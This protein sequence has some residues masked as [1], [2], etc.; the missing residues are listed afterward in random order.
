MNRALQTMDSA[1]EECCWMEGNGWRAR[2]SGEE[3]GYKVHRQLV[4]T[5]GSAA[6][7]VTC[8]CSTPQCTP[9]RIST[10]SYLG[11]PRCTMK[12]CTAQLQPYPD[13]YS[14]ISC[15]LMPSLLLRPLSPTCLTAVGVGDRRFRGSWGR[16]ESGRLTCRPGSGQAG[17]QAGGQVNEQLSKQ[18][19]RETEQ[20]HR[21][22]KHMDAPVLH[23]LKARD[24][25][26]V[27]HRLKARDRTPVLPCTSISHE[28][29]LCSP[30]MQSLL[31][32]CPAQPF[33]LFA[34]HSLPRGNCLPSLQLPALPLP[35][36]LP[37]QL[38]PAC[39]RTRPASG[40]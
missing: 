19:K 27:L 23:R 18:L 22:W 25:T 16:R 3:V 15:C 38:S 31:A 39:P 28:D 1:L 9:K 13:S 12:Q 17:R 10:V 40:D 35:L 29:T 11:S 8:R 26:P 30:E 36:P 7:S 34:H 6:T 37:L 33:L 2:K 20:V 32:S 24:R 5:A 14:L 21:Q 4:G